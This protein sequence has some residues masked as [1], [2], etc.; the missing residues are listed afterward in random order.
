MLVVKWIKQANIMQVLTSTLLQICE[1]SII[2]IKHGV[3][4]RSWLWNHAEII[5]ICFLVSVWL[6]C[7]CRWADL[8]VY[9]P[10]KIAAVSMMSLLC[11]SLAVYREKWAPSTEVTGG[12]ILATW[13]MQ[14]CEKMLQRS[15]NCHKHEWSQSYHDIAVFISAVCCRISI[16]VFTK[17]GR[18]SAYTASVRMY[19]EVV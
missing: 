3:K 7:C 11:K 10:I 4:C 16:S 14:I 1:Y 17:L 15:V 8:P 18:S 13:T 9:W 12:W 6:A 5:F 2:Y 19:S